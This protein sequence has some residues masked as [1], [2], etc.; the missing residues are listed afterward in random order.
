MAALNARPGE[1]PVMHAVP[2]TDTTTA[3][4]AAMAVLLA[5]QARHR[6]GHGQMVEAAMYDTALANL[7]FRGYEFLA[8]G[9][10]PELLAMQPR[11]GVPRGQFDTAD[12]AIWITGGSDKMFQ[13]FAMEVIGK[14]EWAED[15]RFATALDHQTNAEWLLAEINAILVAR[16]SEHWAD[17]CARAG[18]PCG[19]LRTA[20]EALMSDVT[21]ERGM[22]YRVDHPTAGTVPIIA[23]PIK[24]GGTP[25]AVALAP[26][27][28]GEHTAEV[29]GDLL[30]YDDARIATL[31]EIGAVSLPGGSFT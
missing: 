17:L 4:N 10:E 9:E 16:P 24:L 21:Q 13:A 2:M 8:S 1:R 7:T 25:A 19:V 31:V 12:G 6:H 30:G 27:L 20:G 3:M 5:I 14:S 23:T 22:L 26:P 15:P 29:L 11:Q 28:L 18:I